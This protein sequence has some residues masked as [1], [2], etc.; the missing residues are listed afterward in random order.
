MNKTILFIYL[1]F[2]AFSCAAQIHMGKPDSSAIKYYGTSYNPPKFKGGHDAL[3]YY[4]KNKLHY[5]DTA[6]NDNIT[7]RVIVHFMINEDGSI[8][9]AKVVR[10]ISVACDS[11]ALRAVNDMPAWTPAYY[12]ERPIKVWGTIPIIFS[13]E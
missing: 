5:P 13:L 6:R 9:N 2:T 12:K 3:M 11:V 10:G 7:G 1:L 4:M 8:S